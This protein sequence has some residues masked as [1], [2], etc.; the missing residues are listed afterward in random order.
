LV[1]L[2]L[3]SAA[4]AV[5]F[6]RN[7]LGVATGLG[8]GMVLI[9]VSRA[10]PMPMVFLYQFLAVQISLNAFSDLLAAWFLNSNGVLTDA[11]LMAQATH[12]PGAAWILIWMSIS[13]IAV[14]SA[15]RHVWSGK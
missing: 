14:C 9:G 15:L 4:A 7:L 3:G 13:L 10:R 5:L 12:V 2:G 8:M 11:A 1:L 6:A